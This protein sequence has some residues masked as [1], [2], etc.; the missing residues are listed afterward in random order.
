MLGNLFFDDRGPGTIVQLLTF[1]PVTP[2]EGGSQL[3]IL[4]VEDEVALAE[5]YRIRLE[6]QGYLVRLAADG[7]SGLQQAIDAVPDLLLL[8]LRLPGFDGFHL[9]QEL[10]QQEGTQ[11]LPTI[12]LSNFG[13][14]EVLDRSRQLRVLA[15]F[16]K[17]QT[18]PGRLCEWIEEWRT[19]H[20]GVKT[21][22]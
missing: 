4:L 5:M 15:H 1:G 11:N 21:S 17:S 6:R 12:V 14:D 10:R 20:G 8:D 2:M 13:S 9:L 16:V 19:A 7:P 18:P 22:I 3:S